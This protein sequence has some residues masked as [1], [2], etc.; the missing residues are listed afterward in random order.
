VLL[1]NS[2]QTTVQARAGSEQSCS[3]HKEQNETVLLFENL[4]I[5]EV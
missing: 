2:K 1:R 4:K 3:E 5:V